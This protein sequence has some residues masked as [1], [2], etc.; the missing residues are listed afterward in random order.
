MD[1]AQPQL[2]RIVSITGSNASAR[3]FKTVA[4][5]DEDQR[6]TIGRLVGISVERSLI[7]GVVVRISV[8]PPEG[9]ATPDDANLV[10][11]I[12]F[13]GEIRNHG[14][15]R[16]SFQRGVSTY[17]TTGSR[18]SRLRTEDVAV[19]HHITNGDTIEVGRLRLDPTVPAL[20]NFEELLRKHFAVL[21]TTGVG[22][23]TSVALI[24]Q[25]ILKKK[26][27]LRIFLIDP[28]NE[29]GQCFGD[30]AHVITPK[31]LVLPFW[32]F[33]FEEIVD[34]FFRSRPGV[35]EE[36]EILQELIPIAKA[37]FAAGARADRVTLRKSGGVG[38]TADTP[39]PYRVSDLVK[40]IDD[41]MGKLEN[42]SIWTK[43]H[44]LIARIETL[45]N[46]SRYT[47][48]FN[49]LFIEDLMVQVLGDL[50]R[51][52]ING[53]PITVLQLAGFPAEVLDSVVSV[54][55]RMAFEFGVW[56]DGA[57]PLLVACEEA[58]RYAPA[59][60][61][62]GFGPT[63]KALSRI[64]KEG[65]KY[66]V[67]LGAI[68]QR[69]AEI[70]PTIL[71]QCSTV[72]AMRLANDAD[73]A[74]VKSA[75][76]DAGSSLVDFLPSLGNREGIAF[77]EGVPLPTRFRFTDIAADR[78]PR[79]QSGQHVRLE[80]G[81]EV[82]QDFIHAVVDRWRDATTTNQR[83]RTSLMG[84]GGDADGMPPEFAE[85]L[86]SSLLRKRPA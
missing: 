14:T 61:K 40:L 63:R 84:V 82:D 1:S 11:E 23:S 2:G 24:L 8:M 60:R 77:G 38:F 49:N 22:K 76:P 56:S 28:H 17:P 30:M 26:A 80:A 10:A 7:V 85:E 20:I 3:L 32:L 27:N 74:I 35:E 53:K 72:F 34:V 54:V 4:D 46:D 5:V 43:Y 9:E 31:N 39:V 18:V 21:G 81:A 25:E 52:P 36:T 75:V 58:H 73:Q 78:I 48:M 41:R 44:R 33:N 47:F 6:L 68:T 69:P 66:G 59:D 13:M 79:S 29:Y 50:F 67:F 57:A 45:G 62:L 71:S 19:I 86:G 15:D 42:R 64:A 12:D 16:A 37:Q 55:C 70:D 65:R 83:P 51:L